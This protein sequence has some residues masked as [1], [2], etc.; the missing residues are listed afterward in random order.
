[1][2]AVPTDC[3]KSR[4]QKADILSGHLRILFAYPAFTR[5]LVDEAEIMK[6]HIEKV[7]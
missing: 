3:Q 1:M 4:T 5:L 6:Q 2:D 7:G